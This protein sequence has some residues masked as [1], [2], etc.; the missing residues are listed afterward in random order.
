MTT[1]HRV[2]SPA[3]SARLV[4]HWYEI[5]ESK[6]S[7]L[8]SI[9]TRKLKLSDGSSTRVL[10]CPPVVIDSEGY[11]VNGKHRAMMAVTRRQN[12]E[13]IVVETP[14]DIRNHVPRKAYGADTGDGPDKLV[15]ALVNKPTY[16]R[17]I[18]ANGV[19]TVSDLVARYLPF[20][21][22]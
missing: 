16:L 13:A 12:L 17:Q 10:D 8:G 9:P 15:E 2:L 3:E 18:H 20:P 22:E 4:P 21:Q 1:S 5:D 7:R 14:G 11:I 6:L 19:Y